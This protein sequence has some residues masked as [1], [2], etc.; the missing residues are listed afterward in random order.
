M[1][2]GQCDAR[3]TVTFSAAGHHR[4]LTGTKLYCLVTEAYCV[5]NLP[6]VVTWKWNGRESNPR[7]FVSRANT[8]TITPPGHQL[9]EINIELSV[10][11]PVMSAPC[12]YLAR[13]RLW[14][15]Y[16][17][18]SKYLCVFCCYRCPA[19]AGMCLIV[20]LQTVV[21]AASASL[22]SCAWAKLFLFDNKRLLAGRWRLPFRQL[23]FENTDST[24][25]D[26]ASVQ[27]CVVLRS[28]S[29]FVSCNICCNVS[30]VI[31][32]FSFLML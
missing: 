24:N 31:W 20:E 3:P 12:C 25:M 5:N 30:V 4:P 16:N 18:N 19:D 9:I 2:H 21:T 23:P 32:K 6:K 7:P 14:W 22:E 11:Q 10:P 8:L 28:L 26:S 15:N 27:A 1:T 13:W 17:N 29:C